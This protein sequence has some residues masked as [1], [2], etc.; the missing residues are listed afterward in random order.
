V[1]GFRSL[2]VTER[3]DADTDLGQ[4]F[5]QPFHANGKAFA[6]GHFAFDNAITAHLREQPLRPI[7]KQQ[8]KATS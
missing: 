7:K 8:S 6:I 3:P 1:N 5:T 4:I 2:S